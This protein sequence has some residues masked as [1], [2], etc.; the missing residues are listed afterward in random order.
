MI[1]L[2]VDV[3]DGKLDIYDEGWYS[4]TK[5]DANT[6]CGKDHDHYVL[7]ER[8]AIEVEDVYDN[9]YLYEAGLKTADLDYI[10]TK[11]HDG[12]Y[13]L[14]A[15]GFAPDTWVSLSNTKLYIHCNTGSSAYNGQE[16]I[17]T[18]FKKVEDVEKAGKLDMLTDRPDSY[19]FN[20]DAT[21]VYKEMGPGNYE[22]IAVIVEYAG[23]DYDEMAFR[24]AVAEE[25]ASAQP[26]MEG[27]P[28][29]PPPPM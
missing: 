22:V 10:G 12:K 1:D 9:T 3:Y 29:M 7:N 18:N 25:E 8:A 5:T 2:Y 15:S 14:V 6:E 28:G 26:P 17:P 24:Y 20:Y 27:G 4:Y 11:L 16:L 21:V 23:A 19:E 13:E